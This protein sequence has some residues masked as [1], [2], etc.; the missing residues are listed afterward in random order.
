MRI[1]PGVALAFHLAFEF[2]FFGSGGWAVWRV[3]RMLPNPLMF[4][5]RAMSLGGWPLRVFVWC[6]VFVVVTT[7]LLAAA[8]LLW[9]LL[10]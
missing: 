1:L 3:N 10:D 6:I 7:P 8:Q 4:N 2:V 5:G 9:A